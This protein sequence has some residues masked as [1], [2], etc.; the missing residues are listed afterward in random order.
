M[1]EIQLTGNPA[2]VLAAIAEARGEPFADAMVRQLAE[3][4]GERVQS[5][6][7]LAFVYALA[8][9]CKAH[10]VTLSVS[11]YDSLQVWD[12]DPTMGPIYGCGIEDRMTPST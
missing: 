3:L 4:C 7:F 12:A 1:D 8:Q 10:S 9:L 6:K 5:P 2:D 11:G